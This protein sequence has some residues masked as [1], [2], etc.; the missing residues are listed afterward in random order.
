MK[1]TFKILLL[2]FL[3]GGILLGL[4]I[5]KRRP[6]AKGRP[7]P[8]PAAP[9][10]PR[11]VQGEIG[12]RFNVPK[13]AFVFPEKLPLLSV[14]LASFTKEGSSAIATRLGFS[15][16]PTEFEDIK[17]GVKYYW[18]SK[19]RFLVVTL[20]TGTVKYGP[21]REGLPTS[22]DV[23]LTDE[24]LVAI[25]KK[26]LGEAGIVPAEKLK[27]VSLSYLK[28]NEA[29][30]G[31]SETTRETAGLFQVSLAY[32]VSAFEMLTINPSSPL[33]FVR[34]LPDGGIFEA[35][36]VV[37]KTASPGLTEY[38][39]KTYE[40]VAASTSQFRLVS[41]LNGFLN[42]SDLSAK[43]IQKASVEKIRLAYLYEAGE[44][45]FLQPVFVLEG[46]ASVSGTG[47]D[48]AVFYLPAITSF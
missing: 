11:Y 20:K 42:L 6:P 2:L 12:V 26:F 37:F 43:D 39:L 25:A 19:E 16:E 22:A 24:A 21:A 27:G 41:L 38:R 40:E 45:G 34:I 8:A 15:G 17:E 4:F 9:K 1:K 47:V 13:E 48:R 5:L 44:V 14:S 7:E 29:V 31:L 3:G 28:E 36:A 18:T 33:V 46:P 32:W 10:I 30:E 35:Q 23:R